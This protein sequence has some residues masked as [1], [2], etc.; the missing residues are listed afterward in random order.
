MKT[1]CP[2][3]K[4]EDPCPCGSGR[5]FEQCCLGPNREIRVKVPSL[6]P[7]G[8]ATGYAH[9]RCYLR[10]TNDCCNKITLEDT[11]SKNVLQAMARGSDLIEMGGL[12]WKAPGE[13][14][15]LGINNLGSKVLC[16]RHNS[17]LSPLDAAA[18]RLFRTLQEIA[19]DI[20]NDS[21][22]SEGKWFFVGGE[23]I[24]LWCLKVLCG[25]YYSNQITNQH[26]RISNTCKLDVERF[27]R[28]LDDRQFR[29]PCGLYLRV[30]ADG[31]LKVE[32]SVTTSPLCDAD[33]NLLV[34]ITIGVHGIEFDVLMEDPGANFPPPQ[35]PAVFH[36]WHLLFCNS[37]RQHRI[38][39]TWQDR[40]SFDTDIRY[41][42]KPEER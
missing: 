21:P 10:S 14:V 25:L 28:A 16:K 15:Q 36:P 30:N 29:Q 5:I 31:A 13:L 2:P 12:Y 22:S 41:S 20:R 38:V 1:P 18:G 40:T 39:M 42:T 37:R 4:L 7:P 9:Q 26:Q 11:I 32:E 35:Q 34:G 6:T 8:P 24:E 23:L 17:A 33:R 3:W 27:I 19:A